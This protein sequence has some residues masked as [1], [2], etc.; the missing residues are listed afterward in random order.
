MKR[1]LL[2]ALLALSLVAPGRGAGIVLGNMESAGWIAAYN[3][4]IA[5]G[6][7]DATYTQVTGFDV[8][9][10]YSTG[11]SKIT[12]GSDE[13]TAGADGGGLYF[14]IFLASVTGGNVGEYHCDI[15][16]NEVETVAAGRASVTNA[17]AHFSM[18]GLG[19]LVLVNGDGLSLRCDCESGSKTM[20]LSHLGMVAIRIGGTK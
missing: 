9:L 11:A 12:T 13:I 6:V 16:Q 10:G 7:N 3:G 15:F 20:V 2:L 4:D 19:L 17:N 18:V 1:L 5:L 14:V 8:D